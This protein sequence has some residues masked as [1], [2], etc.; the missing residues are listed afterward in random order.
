MI[1]KKQ[2][3]DLHCGITLGIITNGSLNLM[4]VGN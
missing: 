3:K 1:W 4:M 2:Y